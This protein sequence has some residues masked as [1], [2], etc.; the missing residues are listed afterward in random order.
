MGKKKIDNYSRIEN[1]MF[2]NVTY[3]KRKRGLIKKAMEL[4]LLCDQQI[5]L[6]VY[7]NL[8]EKMIVYSS[9]NDFT[10]ESA[11]KKELEQNDNKSFESYTNLNYEHFVVN[12]TVSINDSKEQTQRTKPSKVI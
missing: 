12:Q 6:A 11:H 8:K 7:D 2:R 10:L 1:K 4:S 3:C 5:C 9:S